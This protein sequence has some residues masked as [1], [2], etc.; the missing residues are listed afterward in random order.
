MNSEVLGKKDVIII[1]GGTN[2]VASYSYKVN[3]ILT[4]MVQFILSYSNTNII[5]VNLPHRHDLL[6]TSKTNF[7][8][9]TYNAKLQ[10]ISK[11]FKP[12]SVLEMSSNRTHSTKHGLHMNSYGKEKFANHVAS[13]IEILLKHLNKPK[14]VPPLHWKEEVS[15][16][17]HTTTNNHEITK[18]TIEIDYVETLTQNNTNNTSN[19]PQPRIFTR[20][21]KVPSTMTSDFLWQ[22][23]L[24]PR[25]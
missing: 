3:R 7:D 15:A 16:L 13:Q 24:T 10:N 1:N 2:D 6:N 5:I 17:L 9:Q 4:K 21:K 11:A 14:S 12:V 19:E 23:L 8:I 18:I 25:H 22:I 20:N